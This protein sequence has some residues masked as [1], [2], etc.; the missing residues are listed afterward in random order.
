MTDG[1]EDWTLSCPYPMACSNPAVG[2]PARAVT[3]FTLHSL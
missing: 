1:G 2:A 3:L